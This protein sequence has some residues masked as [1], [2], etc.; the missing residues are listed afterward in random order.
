MQYVK[1]NVLFFGR[2]HISSG[3]YIVTKQLDTVDS[4]GYRTTLSLTRVKGEDADEYD[5]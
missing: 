4:N 3:T 1:L 2:K 5:Y